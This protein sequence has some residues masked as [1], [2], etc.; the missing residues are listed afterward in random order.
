MSNNI[1]HRAQQQTDR[2]AAQLTL[3]FLLLAL[4]I[5]GI[6]AV[7]WFI[8]LQ[9][10]LL[11]AADAN[12]KLVAQ[13]Q[14]ISLAEVLQPRGDTIS[15][16]Q[17]TAA[18]DKIFLAT[19]PVT[20]QPLIVGL[21]LE[22]DYGVV[23]A[24]TDGILDVKYG[25]V[26]CQNCFRVEVPLYAPMTDELLGIALFCV[27]PLFF[28]TLERD[29]LRTLIPESL[30]ILLL[31]LIVWR[32]VL[33][34]GRRLR[35]EVLDRQ[36]A[37]QE[38]YE[39]S[40]AKSQ[41]L[42]NMSHEIRTPINAIQ[43]L[44]YL[45]QQNNLPSK[46]RMQLNKMEHSAHMLLTIVND[47]L[48][49]S[50]IEAQHLELD[51]APFDLY[52]IL[53]RTRSMLGFRAIEKGLRL[54]FHEDE[55]VPKYLRGDP[56]R[57]GQ[58]LLNLVGNAIKFT[59][60]GEIKVFIR[61]VE[62]SLEKTVLE[63]S[64]QDTGIGITPE[65]QSRL[66]QLFSQADA[67]IT[68]QFGGTGL[69]LAISQRLVEMMGG[70]IEVNS[71]L[72]EGSIFR[73]TAIFGHAESSEVEL[74]QQ[75]AHPLEEAA[76]LRGV[77]VLLVE[78]Q[79]LNQEVAMEILQQAGLQVEIACNG[80]EALCKV[81]ENP[82]GFHVV[83]MDLQMPVLDGYEATRQ[84]RTIPHC[85]TLPVIA[86]TANVLA[87]ERER[88]LAAGMNDYLTKPIDVPALYRALRHWAKDAI[89]AAEQPADVSNAEA[90]AETAPDAV[91]APPLPE[92][93]PG[94]DV[95]A[96]LQRLGGNEALYRKLLARFPGQYR[97]AL[98]EIQA[99]LDAGE[100]E[101]AAQRAHAVAGVAG[102]LAAKPLEQALRRLEQTIA[103]SSADTLPQLLSDA[104][105][106]LCE[107]LASIA[108]LDLDHEAAN[109]TEAPNDAQTCQQQPLP[110]QQSWTEQAAALA[111][112]LA[113]RDLKAKNQ[114]AELMQRIADPQARQQLHPVGQQ[115]ER[116]HFAD[117][118][119]ILNKAIASFGGA[120]AEPGS[121]N[122]I[123]PQPTS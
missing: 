65:Q 115:I 110:D 61:T 75:P 3:P 51:S 7:Y 97:L 79:P 117:A 80:Q 71:A 40:R 28:Q 39:A 52:A 49:F 45:V 92:A 113:A 93:A 67:S 107:A 55:G 74:I 13:A 72:G 58:V 18:I 60:D 68:R 101:Q 73:F 118:L 84:L 30:L 122:L 89:P 121:G 43:G 111:E 21:A 2:T 9:P 32:W 1:R 5:A 41:F 91:T 35:C 69:G 54:T 106:K 14:A 105:A 102:N 4:A 98:A 22:L 37:E 56:D 53:D 29:I 112:L 17:V 103:S 81:Q 25:Q 86:M 66:F 16:S 38:A 24:A 20:D 27:S 64:V 94:L 88:C 78:D 104:E 10:R 11:L 6:T 87:G 59:E 108:Q 119:R 96:G 33:T 109:E 83:L 34:L 77:R 123:N 36:R 31:L 23:P 19:D 116:L 48:D 95:A 76:Q 46:L 26:D 47:I 82:K 8:L 120:A 99:A 63:F 114:F 62:Y 12:A 50:K 44:I 85:A 57:L 100:R 90:E 70:R 42:A 15:V